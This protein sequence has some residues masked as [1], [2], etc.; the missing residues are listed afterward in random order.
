MRKFIPIQSW[1]CCDSDHGD[2][3]WDGVSSCL[4]IYLLQVLVAID[5][6]E[7]ALSRRRLHWRRE[8]SSGDPPTPSPC[9]GSAVPL[10]SHPGGQ[11]HLIHLAAAGTELAD[12]GFDAGLD[13]GPTF[14]EDGSVAGRWRGARIAEIGD[15]EPKQSAATA[16]RRRARQR[17]AG[18]ERVAKESSREATVSDQDLNW[19]LCREYCKD[20]SEY[21][22]PCQLNPDGGSIIIDFMTTLPTYRL[23][24][25]YSS[26]RFHFWSLLNKKII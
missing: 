17:R 10:P 26:K 8:T 22:P 6:P 2:K 13:R 12:A 24:A 11:Q 21:L 16:S 5:G 20:F 7:V 9:K 4:R 1:A 14:L 15:G 23:K 25:S 19:E 3:I 18:G